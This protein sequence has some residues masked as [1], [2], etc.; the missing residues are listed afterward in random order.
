M[1]GTRDAPAMW[2]EHLEHTFSSIGFKVSSV[3]PCVYHHPD[4]EVCAVAHVDDVLFEGSRS[5]LDEEVLSRL[6]KTYKLKAEFLGPSPERG[7]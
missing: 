6:K 2:Q 3:A 7:R 4:L 1:Y 5:A